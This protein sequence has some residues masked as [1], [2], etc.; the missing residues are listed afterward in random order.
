MLFEACFNI[1]LV[2][3]CNDANCLQLTF[4]VWLLKNDMRYEDKQPLLCTGTISRAM[5]GA[6][7]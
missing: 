4:L 7:L 5:H 6:E 1:I 3:T 2:V